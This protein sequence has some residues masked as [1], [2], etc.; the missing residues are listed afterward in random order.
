MPITDCYC[1]PFERFFLSFLNRSSSFLTKASSRW[2]CALRY[3]AEKQID[4]VRRLSTIHASFHFLWNS[5]RYTSSEWVS[6][7]DIVNVFFN[8]LQSSWIEIACQNFL[9]N[10]CSKRFSFNLFLLSYSF[11]CPCSNAQVSV[12][13]TH[14]SLPQPPEHFYPLSR[15][16]FAKMLYLCSKKKCFEELFP[17]PL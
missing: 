1:P 14:V 2:D 5:L 7:C 3:S 11:S 6:S 4:C 8:L 12:A 15:C 16:Y 9:I 13:M 10:F 17:S